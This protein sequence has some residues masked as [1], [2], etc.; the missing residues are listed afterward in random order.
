MNFSIGIN[1]KLFKR[2]LVI[3]VCFIFYSCGGDGG[4]SNSGPTGTISGSV[5]GTTILAIDDDGVIISSDNTKKRTPDL[6]R[7]GDG[8]K[9]SYSFTVKNIPVGMSIRIYLVTNEDVFPMTFEKNGVENVLSLSKPTDI[10]LGFISVEGGEAIPEINPLLTKYVTPEA[11]D[12]QT[13]AISGATINDFVGTWKGLVW[14]H[15]DEENDCPEGWCSAED[16]NDPCDAEDGYADIEFT[17]E[18]KEGK[19]VGSIHE[20]N[21]GWTANVI[22]TVFDEDKAVY[23][24][25]LANTA[26]GIPNIPE[27]PQEGDPGY[28]DCRDWD[29]SFTA[30][31]KEDSSGELNIMDLTGGG[32][33]GDP[34]GKTFCGCNGGGTGSFSDEI[35][36]YN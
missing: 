3:L 19:L 16:D 15:M 34:G 23:K 11:A 2:L 13:I 29:V 35:T 25:D 20:I 30:T 24:F 1:S 6:D 31:L 14:Y 5:S 8:I 22:N 27:E 21:D 9:E 12:I 17:L 4:S 18:I 36:R 10:N 28:D 26:S 32:L 33:T 7:D